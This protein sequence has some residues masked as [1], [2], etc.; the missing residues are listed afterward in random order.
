MVSGVASSTDAAT[1]CRYRLVDIGAVPFYTPRR[2]AGGTMPLRRKYT[3][4]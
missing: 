2:L 4:I 3:A 1:V